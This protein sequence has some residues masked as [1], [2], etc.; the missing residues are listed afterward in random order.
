MN[1]LLQILLLAGTPL[2]LE[3]Q[4]PEL[5]RAVPTFPAGLG[6]RPCTAR[7]VSSKALQ[8]ALNAQEPVI[9]LPMGASL[10]GNWTVWPRASSDTG[11][12]VLR[13]DTVVTSGKRI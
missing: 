3:A 1:R 7:P 8:T 2:A 6:E 10:T 13:G 5:P 11:W 4:V 12:S 9:C